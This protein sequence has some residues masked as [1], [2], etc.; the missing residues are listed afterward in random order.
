MVAQQTNPEFMDKI[1]RGYRRD[2]HYSDAVR[3]LQRGEVIPNLRWERQLLVYNDKGKQKVVIPPSS[4]GD[5]LK[6]YHDDPAGG[7]FGVTRTY[8]RIKEHYWWPNVSVDVR[9]YVTSCGICQANKARNR[10]PHGRLQP[11]PIPSRRW[12][13]VAMDFKVNLPMVWYQGAE[14]NAI[15]VVIDRLSKQSHFIPIN[16]ALSRT[17]LAEVF[18][19]EIWKL[20]GTPETIVCDRDKR[21]LSS[22]WQDFHSYLGTTIKPSTSMHPQTDGQSERVIQTLNTYLKN[23]VQQTHYGWFKWLPV[24]EFSYNSSVQEST[25]YTP[26]NMVYGENPVSPSLVETQVPAVRDQSAHSRFMRIR[27][28][29]A[30]C[31]ENFIGKV[32]KFIPNWIGP[33]E[34]R[35][36]LSRLNYRLA[37]PPDVRIHPVLHVCNLTR[38]VPRE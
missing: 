24:A 6:T 1:R 18:I 35:Q 23:Y 20:H 10:Y 7:H 31:T 5:I 27:Q 32:R 17:K 14:Y 15:M 37:L 30:K 21:F 38:H 28:M 33:F 12:Q 16:M 34:V 2:V 22:F 3:K 4:R 13:H 9:K 25:G 11:L 19:K 26:F 8:E 36:K 29:I